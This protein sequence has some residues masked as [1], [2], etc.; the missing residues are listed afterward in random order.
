MT[1]AKLQSKPSGLFPHSAHAWLSDS[2]HS[3]LGRRKIWSLVPLSLSG[4]HSR[5]LR[6]DRPTDSFPENASFAK[7]RGLLLELLAFTVQFVADRF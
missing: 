3:P 2:I 6:V 5:V 1:H 7:N 4:W